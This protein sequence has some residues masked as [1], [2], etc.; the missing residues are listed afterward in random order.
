MSASSDKTH[1]NFQ[2][3]PR[4]LNKLS[5]ILFYPTNKKKGDLKQN[6]WILYLRD[7]DVYTCN[8]MLCSV[9]CCL[10]IREWGPKMNTE[11]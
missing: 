8:R 10:R 9:S 1:R 11:S 6:N 2:E 3:F 5:F 7:F 4:M